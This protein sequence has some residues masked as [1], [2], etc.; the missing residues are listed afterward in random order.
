MTAIPLDAS[1][2]RARA[3]DVDDPLGAYRSR[4]LLPTAADG[5][6]RVYLAGQSLGAQPIAARA[7]VE[8][9]LD[10]WARL[11]VGGWFDQERPWLEA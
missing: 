6:P 7:A 1:E 2:A 4:F 5:T 11:G 9:E 8:R 3:F 10:A